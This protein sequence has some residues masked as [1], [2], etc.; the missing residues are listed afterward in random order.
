MSPDDALVEWLRDRHLLLILD[1]GEHVLAAVR[2]VVAKIMGRCPHV[3]TLV[4]S[5]APLEL[6][7]ERVV[8]VPMLSMRDAVDLFEG[9]AAAVGGPT[10]FWEVDQDAIVS[11]CE[12]LDG[13]PLA[14]ELAAA[15]YVRCRCGGAQPPGRPVPTLD[16]GPTRK[17]R[18]SSD[19]AS[20]GRLVVPASLRC[21]A[22]LVRA[23]VGLSAWIRPG[24]R[25]GGLFRRDAR[26]VGNRG[27]GHALVARSMVVADRDRTGIRFRL[28]E[29]LRDYARE[30]RSRHV[31]EDALRSRHLD[32]Y[33]AVAQNANEVCA[34]PHQVDG[35]AVFDREWDNLRA[36]HSWAVET[37]AVRASHDLV[38]LTAHHAVR[39]YRH[40]HEVWA[41]MSQ[42]VE[43]LP[44]S[45]TSHGWAANWALLAG[46][47]TGPCSWPIG[48][49]Q[50]PASLTIRKPRSVGSSWPPS[51][52]RR[53]TADVR[54]SRRRTP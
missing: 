31:G 32:H 14:I 48:A 1:N 28:L 4:T 11:I 39:R 51:N 52:S 8:V 21:R 36:A 15:A 46:M 26:S 54:G 42:S 53:V 43:G 5:R 35:D 13:I 23:T 27:S 30:H 34:G 25:R 20:D 44:T 24:R 50:W 2:S 12:R 16:T 22:S 41:M 19:L 3:T 49:S 33:L 38:A 40:E 17:R 9:C 47:S 10:E 18:T 37:K 29:T 45:A 6:V 7:G